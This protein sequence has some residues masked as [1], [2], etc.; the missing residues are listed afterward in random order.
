MN[1][2]VF[3]KRYFL[4]FVLLAIIWEKG[5]Y[6]MPFTRFSRF[7][8]IFYFLIILFFYC[9]HIYGK[10]IYVDYDASG[11]NNGSSWENAYIYLQNALS[12]AKNSNKPVEVLVAEGTY[13]PD[14]GAGINHGNRKATFQIINDVNLSGG[15]AGAGKSDPT[16]RNTEL[17]VTILS[18]DLA[19]N[20]I[21]VNDP[22]DLF[23]ETTRSENSLHVITING[24]SVIDGIKIIGGN[25][26]DLSS[27]T[28][29]KGGG[30]FNFQN[31]LTLINCQFA[32]NSAC[33]GGGLY[34]DN[35]N[36]L[37][38][39][40][41]VFTHNFAIDEGGGIHNYDNSK[42]VFTNCIFDRNASE[43]Y[44]GGLYNQR[45]NPELSCCLFIG[46]YAEDYGGGIYD[47]CSNILIN[48]C[49]FI[50]NKVNDSGGGLYNEN[51]TGTITDCMFISNTSKEDGAGIYNELSSNPTISHCTFLKNN[52][53]FRGGGIYNSYYSIPL[54]EDCNFSENLTNN[55]GA[56]MYNYSRSNP[57]IKNCT[58]YKNIAAIRGGGMQND[59]DSNPVIS[60]CIFSM[61]EAGAG[62]G[63]FNIGNSI[64]TDCVFIENSAK[65]DGGGLY[66]AYADNPSLVNCT[67]SNN[68]S[69]SNGGAIF[70]D[71]S[72]LILTN[73]TLAE[74]IAKG[75]A[76]GVYNTRGDMKLSGCIFSKNVS[77]KYA[78]GMLNYYNSP[79]YIN[80]QF[81]ENSAE[82]EGA[83]IYNS[84]SNPELTSC[85]F[86]R[87]IAKTEGG[88]IYNSNSNSIF[89]E[90]ILNR[91][92]SAKGGAI[93]NWNSVSTILNCNFIGNLSEEKGGGLYNYKSK[94]TLANCVFS[95]NLAASSGAGIC[96]LDNCI[97]NAENCTFADNL[98]LNGSDFSCF[99]SQ[100][101]MRNDISLKNCIIWSINYGL[102]NGDNSNIKLMYNDINGGH[103]NIYDP[104]EMIIWDEGNINAVPL[105]V[106]PGYWDSNDT[107]DD[108]TD[109]F[110]MEG[111]YHLKSSA[112]R[113]DPNGESW[114]FDDVN[115][116]CI[117][118]G[119]PNSPV[120]FEPYPNGMFINMGA[121][122]GTDQASKSPSGLHAKYGGGSGEP[123]NPYLIYTPMHMN[124]I[125]LYTDDWNKY[126]KLMADIDMSAYQDTSYNIIGTAYYDLTTIPHKFIYVP[127]T[128]NFDGDNHKISNLSYERYETSRVGL[129]GYV[130]NS[131]TEITNVI[132]IDPNIN[133]G[134]G[135]E[136][137]AIAGHLERGTI[138]NCHV[139]SG[140]ISGDGDV[141]GLIGLN[142]GTILC[143][144]S[145]ADV[146]GYSYI[147][148]LVGKC[149]GSIYE[150]CAI[151]R[152]QVNYWGG[153]LVGCLVLN[154][155]IVENCY[156]NGNILGDNQIGGLI[157][158][159]YGGNI[160]NCY[161]TGSVSGTGQ[162]DIGGLIG[163]NEN[164]L[165]QNSFWDTD[166]SGNLNSSGGTGQSATQMQTKST[167]TDAGWDFMDETIN[168]TDDIWWIPN[169]INY[170]LL[171]WQVPK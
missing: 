12:D 109:D 120:A 131:N 158:W 17:Y 98:S 29:S 42:S 136:V 144:S 4:I 153:G 90:C 130:N 100:Q 1:C 37:K 95:G 39:T 40:D 86:E 58:F 162:T 22:C 82:K 135:D 55:E 41:C 66:N 119:D 113:Y 168:G 73:C 27:Y 169:G 167:F 164:G 104:N 31:N 71:R 157:G 32:N 84:I 67:F 77:G 101:W 30:I 111:D 25:A 69:G 89:K 23:N 159:N 62:S 49:N 5:A 18:G 79:K 36:N 80:C 11:S 81:I 105:F 93:N 87:N 94:T 145:S 96:I 7:W 133:A 99:S 60:N 44:G 161:S 156:A 45:G 163:Y 140:N 118:A 112:G 125:G 52:A 107:Q 88:G 138:S 116:P 108:I 57:T 121:Y 6:K 85:K 165:V 122:G 64:L 75:I 151:G 46:N 103:D 51:S 61:N 110:W 78:G 102:W 137:G 91:N 115:S 24:K 53:S 149:S 33:N 72:N 128:G 34:N 124:T 126:F 38:I 146:S 132:L 127:F 9:P 68:T 171:W 8:E 2:F 134:V 20:D 48:D 28:D 150:C 139:I 97:L 10:V 54:I 16:L 152:I 143:S 59:T 106:N 154:K 63:L 47:D 3:W 142:G 14:L 114:V 141:G 13:K 43:N 50:E 15:Y 70:N 92:T 76:G 26:N 170:P 129:F 65:V 21:D 74:N 155:S 19:G 35:S 83:G 147:G 56:G 148:G 166:T 160:L 123:N 117:D